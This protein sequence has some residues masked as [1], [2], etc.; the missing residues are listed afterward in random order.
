MP[1]GRLTWSDETYR[2]FGLEPQEAKITYERFLQFIHPDD[3][4]AVD[5][6]YMES[7][8]MNKDNSET[9]FRVR[10]RGKKILDRVRT[11]R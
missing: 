11:S 5:S 9:E 2:I 8:R 10:D 3:R 6:A 7:I 4:D 1:S